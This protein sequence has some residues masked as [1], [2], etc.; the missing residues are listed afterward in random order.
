MLRIKVLL[1]LRV[2]R[3]RMM[4]RVMSR[5]MNKIKKIKIKTK[6][7]IVLNI[8]KQNKQKNHNNPKQPPPNNP[9]NN[10][11]NNSSPN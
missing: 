8:V 9:P 11:Y 7:L 2:K 3:V 4:I 10:N 1:E 5:K 6:Q